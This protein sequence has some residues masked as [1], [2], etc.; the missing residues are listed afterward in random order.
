MSDRL[1]SLRGLQAFWMAAR[2]S[3]FRAA[4][5]ALHLTPSA[6][7]HAIRALERDLDVVLFERTAKGPR[8]TEIGADYYAVVAKSFEALQAGSND[9]RMRRRRGGLVLNVVHTFA[10]NW[11]VPRLPDFHA[12]HPDFTLDIRIK[13][14][15]ERIEFDP[16]R[17]DVAIRFGAGEWPGMV[18]TPLMPC[19]RLP[20]CNA[21]IAARLHS[22]ADLAAESWLHL[23]I[24]PD[25]WAEFTTACG[26]PD[27]K[28]A[29]DVV[30]EDPEI[31]NRAA[32]SGLGVAL[33]IDCIVA[34]YIAT[35]QLVAPF[36]FTMPSTRCY[37]FL[38]R[39]EHDA[40]PRVRLFRDWLLEMARDEP[41]SPARQ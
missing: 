23:S 15:V 10:A 30:F 29:A 39:P 3:S 2:L 25:A 11:L 34:P 38:C 13:A 22:L 37:W 33:G 14:S 21:A 18:G 16:G 8:L 27:L 26:M 9:V 20:V 35:G 36:D 6:I 24:D 1:P 5:E 19:R 4:A 41:V 12:R 32:V 40:D 28:G 7:S 31:R 17:I